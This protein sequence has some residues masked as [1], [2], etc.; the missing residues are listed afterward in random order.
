MNLFE[1]I[2][3]YNICVELDTFF[4]FGIVC[5]K[6]LIFHCHKQVLDMKSTL[7]FKDGGII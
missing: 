2:Y 4:I 7:V 6:K 3:L 5:K 1:Y